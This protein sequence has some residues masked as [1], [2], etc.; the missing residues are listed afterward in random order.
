M[1][2]LSVYRELRRELPHESFVYIADSRHV[3]YGDKS[4]SF[5]E[6]RSLLLAQFLV[7]T[8]GVKAVVIACNTAT[9]FAVRSV[10]A[11][12]S[13]PIVALEPALRPAA[14]ATKTGV[15][16]VLATAGTLKS[17]QFENLMDR[18]GR[19]VRVVAEPGRGL[20]EQVERGDLSSAATRAIVAQHMAPMIAAGA[21]AV[22]LGSTHYV[23]LRPVIQ[24]VV[25][26]GV[27]LFDSGAAVARRLRQVLEAEGLLRAPGAAPS[28]QFWTSGDP[29][30]VGRAASQLMGCEVVFG[31]LPEEFV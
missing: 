2:G 12:F 20:V 7:E 4:E 10:R 6:Q 13:V 9:A 21:D 3:P 31:R 1:G 14:A 8:R 22:V 29:A 30:V 15:V 18:F 11:R 17:S 28:D 27:T 25:G 26:P 24:D 19:A 5:I 23:L 16:G